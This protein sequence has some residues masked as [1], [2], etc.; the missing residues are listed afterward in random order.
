MSTIND[1]LSQLLELTQDLS[2]EDK[3]VIETE[4]K[5]VEIQ[6]NT[7]R[8]FKALFLELIS[9]YH[10]EIAISN[11]EDVFSNFPENH[12][13]YQKLTFVKTVEYQL[14]Q[15]YR[16]LDTLFSTLKE[17]QEKC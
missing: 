4:L 13:A 2:P 9:E 16:A 17:T 15:Y 6:I 12:Q 8:H 3:N 7:A 11:S 10:P 14:E 1:F 5:T